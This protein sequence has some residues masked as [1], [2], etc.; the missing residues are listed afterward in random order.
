MNRALTIKTECV[1]QHR[2]YATTF[3]ILLHSGKEAEMNQK[4]AARTQQ[5]RVI[6]QGPEADVALTVSLCLQNVYFQLV[7]AL[8]LHHFVC[9]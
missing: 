8:I 9:G 1:S 7:Y 6:S 5:K 3:E 2:V 4:K